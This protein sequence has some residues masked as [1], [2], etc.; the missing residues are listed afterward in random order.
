[1]TNISLTLTATGKTDGPEGFEPGWT[2]RGWHSEGG[3]LIPNYPISNDQAA[4]IGQA[5]EDVIKSLTGI[6]NPG[7][8]SATE[9]IVSGSTMIKF[10]L[11]EQLQFAE[12]QARRVAPL[13]KRLEE[14][15]T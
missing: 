5:Y 11:E 7:R 10:A 9:I 6:D 13:R 14:I 15:A 1:M 12:E 3:L 4:I 2:I 8:T